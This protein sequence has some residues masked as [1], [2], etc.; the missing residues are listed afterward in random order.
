VLAQDYPVSVACEVLDC[1]RSSFY[2]PVSEP[3]DEA[4]LIAAIKTV[5]AE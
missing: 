4:A 2:H 1:T 5:A 3:P